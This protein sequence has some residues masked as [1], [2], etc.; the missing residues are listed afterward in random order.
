MVGKKLALA[1]ILGSAFLAQPARAEGA[2]HFFTAEQKPTLYEAVI[3]RL[4]TLGIPQASVKAVVFRT[5]GGTS[6]RGRG[7]VALNDRPGSFLFWLLPNG[8]IQEVYSLGPLTV[9][10]SNIRHAW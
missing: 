1:M 3:N 10:S 6:F 8:S 5:D 4:Q 2:P 7:W 9:S